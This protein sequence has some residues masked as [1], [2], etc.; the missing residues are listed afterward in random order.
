MEPEGKSLRGIGL[1]TLTRS[2]QE[3]PVLESSTLGL[4]RRG[5]ETTL[6]FR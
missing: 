2:K 6:R 4:M 5:L 1:I 3:S